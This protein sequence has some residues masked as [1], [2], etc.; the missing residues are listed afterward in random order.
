MAMPEPIH[1]HPGGDSP[2]P[3]ADDIQPA[4]L[5]DMAAERTL[6]LRAEDLQALTQRVQVGEVI[7]RTR[8]VTE[9]RT[10]QVPVSREEV[11]IERRPVERSA[12]D[13]MLAASGAPVPAEDAAMDMAVCVRD[14]QPGEVLRVPVREEEVVIQKRPVVV[15]EITIAKRVH[16]Q[17]QRAAATVRHEELRLEQ[18]GDVTIAGADA[19]SPAEDRRQR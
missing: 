2:H 6:Q 12:A 10:F 7:V 19:A 1:E 14:L 9:T 5:E 11:V 17:T 4:T 15:E 3:H 18:Q 8:V 13:S 16:T